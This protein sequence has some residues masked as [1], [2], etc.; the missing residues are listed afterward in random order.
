MEEQEF[1]QD[2]DIQNSEKQECGE[3]AAPKNTAKK[4]GRQEE[5]LSC[6]QDLSYMLSAVLLI[7]LFLLRIAVVDGSSMVPT[8]QNGDRLLMCSNL[9]RPTFRKGDVVVVHEQD[10]ESR[11][12]L[13][14][15]V[16]A[17]EGETVDID[18]E[19]GIVY[20][21]GEALEEPYVNTPTNLDE[22]MVFPATVPEGCVFVM[23][24]NRNNSKDSRD[25]EV[26]FVDQREIFGK[27]LLILLPGAD[28]ETEKRDFSRIG[29]VR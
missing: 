14:K 16:I 15:R 18:F 2:S 5:F 23:G 12:T 11:Y 4:P 17:T 29:A 26:G 1:S 7:F 28:R 13:V 9:L 3:K 20:V 10:F 19:S 22:G 6:L 25:P 27:A 21:D 24:D 8:L